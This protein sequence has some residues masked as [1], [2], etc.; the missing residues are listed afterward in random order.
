MGD[1]SKGYFLARRGRL[2]LARAMN[3]VIF[4]KMLDVATLAA[5]MLLGVVIM[6]SRGTESLLQARAATV[7]GIAGSVAVLAVLGLYFIPTKQILGFEDL[8]TWLG[9]K[10]K[11]RKLHSLV[12]TS[13][14]VIALLQSRG[15]RRGEI[16]LL[17]ILIWVLHLV[18]IY[19]FFRCL[20]A[21]PPIGQFVTLVPLAIFIGLLPVTIAGFGTRDA[22]LVVLFSQYPNEVML[23]IALYVNLR[24]LLP[25]AAGVPFLHNYLQSARRQFD[26]RT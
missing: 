5:F 22:A 3:I 1:L 10:P 23:G 26:L 19:F 2:D 9:N 4:E 13:H 18:Q 7:A 25:A 8:L 15:A 6:A 16:L 24:Y 12:A 21:A 14:E 20:G 11:L 17:S